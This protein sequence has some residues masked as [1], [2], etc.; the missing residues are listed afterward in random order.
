MYSKEELKQL[1]LR[2]WENFGKYCE[3]HPML[4]HK[5]RKWILH[6]TKIKNVALRF[7][8]NRQNAKVLLELNSRNENRR[9]K[10]FEILERYKL[11]M[12]DGF[13]EG[14]IWD[15]F[16]E[17]EDSHQEVCRIYTSLPNVDIHRQNQWP[18]IYSFFIRNMVQLEDNF[19]QVRDILREELQQQ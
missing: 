11:I 16:H 17:R 1:H 10:A 5:S 3:V 9:L 7:E 19:M 2:F 14:L 13:E 18:D 4:R 12:E 8:V 6:R 15:F